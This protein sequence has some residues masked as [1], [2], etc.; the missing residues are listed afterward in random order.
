MAAVAAE[1]L[2][3]PIASRAGEFILPR[4]RLVCSTLKR[5]G[6][7]VE[8]LLVSIESAK[9]RDVVERINLLP[10]SSNTTPLASTDKVSPGSNDGKKSEES[11]TSAT[12]FP[13]EQVISDRAVGA[14]L[15]TTVCV[16]VRGPSVPETVFNGKREHNGRIKNP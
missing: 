15:D 3:N 7:F 13:N 14:P 9:N 4:D 10:I 8:K 6:V 16:T 5:M 11:K 12:H 2:N 1:A